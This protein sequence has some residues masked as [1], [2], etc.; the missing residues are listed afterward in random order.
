MCITFS[1]INLLFQDV[2]CIRNFINTTKI[3]SLFITEEIFSILRLRYANLFVASSCFHPRTLA[4]NS[5][6]R[7]VV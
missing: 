5:A 4:Q 2:Y 6:R 1:I 3:L 7:F